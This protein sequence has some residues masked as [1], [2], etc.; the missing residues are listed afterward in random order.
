MKAK[1]L[2][3]DEKLVAIERLRM[4]QMGVSSGQWKWDHVRECLLDVKTWLWFSMLTAVSIPSGGISTFGPLIVKAF[5]YDS[6]T[7]TLFNM[8]FGAV[9]LT[10]TLGGAFAATHWKMKS[11]ILAALC[12]PPIIGISIMLSVPYHP[13]N[14]G[15]LLF[16]YYITSVYPAISPL[17]YSWSG[18]NT[19]KVKPEQMCYPLH[20]HVL[21]AMP[22]RFRWRHEAQNNHWHLVH[23]RFCR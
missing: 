12:I 11:P 15:V 16:A 13:S 19:G 6:F 9:Q 21:T 7:T 22:F 3:A 1:F 10:A 17:I 18:Q 8:P 5:G 4:N 14:R 20:I 23:W 2:S